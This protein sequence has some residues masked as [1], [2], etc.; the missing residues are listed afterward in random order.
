MPTASE[1]F[2]NEECIEFILSAMIVDQAQTLHLS[3][4][5]IDLNC[6]CLALVSLFRVNTSYCNLLLCY[7]AIGI[8]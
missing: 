8:T 2:D 6:L 4:S 3:A 7:C 1:G 5:A